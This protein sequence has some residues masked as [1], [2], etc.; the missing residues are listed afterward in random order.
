[1]RKRKKRRFG[2]QA[3]TA[4]ISTT[5]VLLLVGMV[6]FL[7]LAAHNMSGYVR[8][9]MSLTAEIDGGQSEADMFRLKAEVEAM[10]FARSVQYISKEQARHEYVQAMGADPQKFLEYNP[11]PA[12]LEVKLNAAYANT[13]SLTTVAGQLGAD[14]RISR[15][16]YQEDL[17]DVVNR[18]IRTV[19]IALVALAAVLTLISFALISNTV[20]LAMHSQRFLIYTMKLVGASPAFIRRPFMRRNFMIGLA[21]TATADVLLWA[22]AYWAVGIEPQLSTVVTADTMLAV[23]GV[24]LAFGLTITMLCAYMSTSRYIGMKASDLYYI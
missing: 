7:V 9:N 16:E 12:M 24:V 23:S 2:M 21:A 15:V 6:T 20:R 13:D 5:L 3:V 18:N 17:M 14:K 11:L 19:S 10:P 4:T 8:E 22:A 1:M